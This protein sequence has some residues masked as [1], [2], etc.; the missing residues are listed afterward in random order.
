MADEIDLGATEANGFDNEPLPQVTILVQYAKDLSFENPNAPTS[1][2]AT[3]QPQ[4]EV[5]VAV[6]AKRAGE[7][8]FES[9]LKITAK[10][11]NDG[12]TA[13]VVELL[14]AGLFGLTNVP[15][16]ALE[17]FLVIEAPRILFPFARRIIADA[18][19]DGGFPPL[20]LDPIDF[21]SLYMAQQ[22]A[23]TNQVGNA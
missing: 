10:A 18:T 19:R 8:V 2:Q 9:E 21:A 22:Q 5:N 4:I 14:Y 1:L 23:G 15:E 7:G 17:P 13:F 11:T 16:E 12:D 3:G 20:M 6:N